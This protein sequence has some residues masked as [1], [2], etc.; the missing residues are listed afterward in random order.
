MEEVAC[1]LC[2]SATFTVVRPGKLDKLSRIYHVTDHAPGTHFRIVRCGNCGL[3]YC[4][5]RPTSDELAEFYKKLNDPA[6]I[7]ESEGRIQSAI[8]QVSDLKRFVPSGRLLELGSACG[9]FLKTARDSG[10]EVTGIEPSDW[11]RKYAEDNFGLSLLE[12]PIQRQR[13]PDEYFDAVCL[14]DV[15]EHLDNPRETFIEIARVTRSGGILYL[16]TPHAQSWLARLLGRYWW[17]LQE[18]HL[19]YFSHQT[20]AR[21]L[22]VTGFEMLEVRPFSREF[23]L[24]YW[25]SKFKRYS[26]LLYKLLTPIAWGPV[27]QF[28]LRISLPDQM[29]VVARKR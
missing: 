10:F 14:F 18:A 23:T 19:F 11:A 29:L 27:G 22:S 13:F 7:V 1:N 17:G 15:L 3:L 24:T 20:M 16:S 25:R 8:P 28:K 12:Y 2:G 5:P 4:S 6:Y 26:G 21:I 9:F